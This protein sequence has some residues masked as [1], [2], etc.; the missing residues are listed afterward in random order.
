MKARRGLILALA[1]AAFVSSNAFA[2]TALDADGEMSAGTSASEMTREALT[3][4][5]TPWTW[6]YDT[7]GRITGLRLSSG[8]TVE[9][10]YLGNSLKP[11]AMRMNGGAWGA[12]PNVFDPHIPLRPQPKELQ[13]DEDAELG[14]A[15][16][17]LAASASSS[18]GNPPAG[19]FPPGLTPMEQCNWQCDVAF[20]VFGAGCGVVGYF[21]LA[22]GAICG[23]GEAGLYVACKISC[24]P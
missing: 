1:V 13:D 4:T 15:M 18:Y 21:N 24:L 5:R 9:V 8:K 6:S 23:V 2:V 19:G 11:H 16:A 3:P 10:Q 17:A 7:H 20:P 14:A 22:L 12:A